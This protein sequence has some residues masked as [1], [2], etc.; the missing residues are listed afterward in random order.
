ME[1]DPQSIKPRFQSISAPNS[2][3]TLFLL[4]HT[5]QFESS[6]VAEAQIN[7]GQ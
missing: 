3:E 2:K 7:I 4:L 5:D 6:G 1:N